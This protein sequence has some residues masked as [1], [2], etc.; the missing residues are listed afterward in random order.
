MLQKNNQLV[1]IPSIWYLSTSL[2]WISP[3]FL[4]FKRPHAGSIFALLLS[5][6]KSLILSAFFNIL[7][8]ELSSCSILLTWLQLQSGEVEKVIVHL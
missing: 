5:L 8:F 7:L 4:T 2:D 1:N 6:L 3:S